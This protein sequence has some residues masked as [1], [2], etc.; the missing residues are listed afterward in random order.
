[1]T[2]E[3]FLALLESRIDAMRG[4]LASKAKEYATGA[5]RLHNF[6]AAALLTRRTPAQ[7]LL[8]MLAKHLVSVV[9]LVEAPTP[10]NAALIDE[11]LGDAI[12]YMVLLEA[13]LKETP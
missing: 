5:D 3:A 11:K 9:D 1:M 12:N 4:T 13:L 2:N 7:S 8:G 6:K 10:P